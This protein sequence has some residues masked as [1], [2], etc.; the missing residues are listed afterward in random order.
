MPSKGVPDA[1]ELLHTEDRAEIVGDLLQALLVLLVD[2]QEGH[3]L[4][5]MQLMRRQPSNPPT[6][7]PSD[8]GAVQLHSNAL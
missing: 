8:I 7:Q 4:Q 1:V 6:L 2:D 5:A 3:S